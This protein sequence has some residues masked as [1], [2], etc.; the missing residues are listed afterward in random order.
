MLS[1]KENAKKY[2]R[3]YVEITNAC[4]M[5]CSF[6]L[7]TSRKKR[8]MTASEFEYVAERLADLTDYVY[9]HVLGEPLLH[10]ELPE[11]IRIASERALKVAI[12]TNG[13]L[14][15]KRGDELISSG[16]YKVSISLHS[17]EGSESEKQAEY[18]NKCLDFADKASKSGVLTVLRLWNRGCDDGRNDS[19]L[20]LVRSAFP[21]G[22]VESDRGIRIRHKLHLEWGDRFEWPRM[23]I[24]VIGDRGFCYGLSD[25]FGILSDGTVVPCCLDRDGDIALGNVFETEL[26]SILSS[27]RAENVRLGFKCREAREEL[28]KRCGYRTRFK[29]Q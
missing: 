18:V 21:D 11:I 1:A 19:T 12:T 26:S 4:N 8:M 15:D 2:K 22:W 3:A 29:I 9:L 17:F 14:L 16:V 24:P 10:P 20:S 13:T 5:S 23:D 6:C 25:H 28:C 27:D 7:G